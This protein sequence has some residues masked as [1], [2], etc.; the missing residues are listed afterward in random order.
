MAKPVAVS[1]LMQRLREL[2]MVET[3]GGL[4][5]A[6]KRYGLSVLNSTATPSHVYLLVDRYADRFNPYWLYLL[7]HRGWLERLRE[8]LGVHGSVYVL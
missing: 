1:W 7:W 3:S 4:F 8:Y 2:F 6:R 5:E